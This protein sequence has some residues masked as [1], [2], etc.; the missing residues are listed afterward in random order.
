MLCA[1]F[2]QRGDLRSQGI[3]FGKAS[4]C[5]VDL[6]RACVGG[7]QQRIRIGLDLAGRLDILEQF[8]RL[9]LLGGEELRRFKHRRLV[10]DG[11]RRLVRQSKLLALF[12][13]CRL[14]ISQ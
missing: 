2:T 1:E 6:R 13:P 11:A 7:R 10:G 14:L 12:K 5:L 9:G 8:A 3:E 4:D